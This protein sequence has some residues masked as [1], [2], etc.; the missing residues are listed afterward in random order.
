MKTRHT[1]IIAGILVMG[2]G[3]AWLL[4]VLDVIPGVDWI[5][6]VGLGMIGVLTLVFGGIN[7]V[8]VVIGPFL[9]SASILSILRQ[10]ERITEKVEVPT[11]IIILGALIIVSYML[12]VPMPDMLQ[13]DDDPA[14]A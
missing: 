14:D 5:W 2:L 6:T 7:R 10:T 12:K 3:S 13:K 8:S 1:G 11:L 4:N 9:M